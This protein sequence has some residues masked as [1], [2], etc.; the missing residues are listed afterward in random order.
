MGGGVPFSSLPEENVPERVVIS[1][2]MVVPKI[3]VHPPR[4]GGM[5]RMMRGFWHGPARTH[6]N[7]Q[8]ICVHACK[9]VNVP[10]R[11]SMLQCSLLANQ[12]ADF[13]A[14]SGIERLART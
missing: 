14:R 9:R 12:R 8:P 7:C 5:R 1:T 6:L 2:R 13:E 10:S 11:P 4:R 3:D